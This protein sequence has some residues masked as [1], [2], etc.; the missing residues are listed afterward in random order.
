MKRIQQLI[1]LIT[2]RFAAVFSLRCR[3][4]AAAVANAVAG[5]MVYTTHSVALI[6]SNFIFISVS[7]GFTCI[8]VGCLLLSCVAWIVDGVRYD[9]HIHQIDVERMCEGDV[10]FVLNCLCWMAVYPLFRSLSLS[11]SRPTDWNGLWTNGIVF[12]GGMRMNFC[13]LFNMWNERVNFL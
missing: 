10:R 7:G 1:K 3:W 4:F 9:L 8:S 6:F 2:F 5:W 12:V 11:V 13:Y